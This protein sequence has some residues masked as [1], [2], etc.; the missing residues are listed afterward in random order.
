MGNGEKLNI[1][2][3]GNSLIANN[4]SKTLL[5]R[6]ILH[7]PQI[8]KNLLSVSQLI[9]CNDITIEFDD[10]D[11]VVKDKETGQILLQRKLREGL[12]QLQVP[13]LKHQI[14][15]YVSNFSQSFS[16]VFYSKQSVATKSIK[17]SRSRDV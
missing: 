2:H 5:L 16:H 12:Y 3:I 1:Q 7:V 8:E 15:P 4:N 9:A 17:V 10:L 13:P 14:Q 6:D 11:C